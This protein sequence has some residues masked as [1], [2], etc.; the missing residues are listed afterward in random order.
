MRHAE[1]ATVVVIEKITFLVIKIVNLWNNLPPSTTDF[2]SFNKFVEW[3][4]VT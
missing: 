1:T 4:R 2:T 3:Q